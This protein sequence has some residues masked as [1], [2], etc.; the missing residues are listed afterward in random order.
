[1]SFDYGC[2]N[3]W[4]RVDM[5]GSVFPDNMHRDTKIFAVGELAQTALVEVFN[6]KSEFEKLKN[7]AANP[8]NTHLKRGFNR[9]EAANYIGVG[10]TKFDDLVNQRRMPQPREIDKRTVWDVCELDEYFEQLPQRAERPR[11]AWS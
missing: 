11:G 8:K 9:S 7:N 1:M 10:T 4:K 2:S 3:A 6:L 5:D